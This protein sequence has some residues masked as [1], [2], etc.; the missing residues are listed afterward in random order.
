[1]VA[2]PSDRKL[3][4]YDQDNGKLIWELDLPNVSEGVPTVYQV[5]GQGIHRVLCRRRPAGSAAQFQYASAAAPGAY[6]VFALP[7]KKK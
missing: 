1:M 5:A 3:H 7:E 2:S 4:A 6:M